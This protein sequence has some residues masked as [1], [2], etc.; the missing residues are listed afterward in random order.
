MEFSSQAVNF[1]DLSLP[2]L[3]AGEL[4]IIRNCADEAENTGRLEFLKKLMYEAIACKKLNLT[5]DCYSGWLLEIERGTKV[6]GDS[7]KN[8]VD[9]ILRRA[10]LNLL[11]NARSAYGGDVGVAGTGSRKFLWYCSDYNRRVCKEESP[12]QSSKQIRGVFREVVHM[13]ATCY[14]TNKEECHH[15]EHSPECPLFST[16]KFSN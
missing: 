1:K 10:S 14:S 12:H 16:E 15:P 6:W 4:N 8:L 9:S 5:L 3:V 7:F 2:Q 11:L 13:R